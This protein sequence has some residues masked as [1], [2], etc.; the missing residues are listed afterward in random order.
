MENNATTNYGVMIVYGAEGTGTL[1]RWW[2][3]DT[4]DGMWSKHTTGNWVHWDITAVVD[5]MNKYSSMLNIIG[6]NA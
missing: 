5:F 4:G 1:N 2:F 3:P 6:N